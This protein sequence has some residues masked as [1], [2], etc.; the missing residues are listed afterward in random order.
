MPEKR[1]HKGDG[2][3][4][5]P[6]WTFLTNHAHVMLCVAATPD[7]RVR[8]IAVNVGITERAVLRILHELEDEGYLSRTRIGRRSEYAVNATLPL[9]HTIEAHRSV[10]DLLNLVR[11]PSTSKAAKQGE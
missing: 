8:D 11:Q 9:R 5:G 3:G 10:E 6:A 2:A 7:M 4:V 1:E